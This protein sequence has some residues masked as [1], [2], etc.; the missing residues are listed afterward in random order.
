YESTIVKQRDRIKEMLAEKE[1]TDRELA[2]YREKSS[3]ISKAIVSAVAKAEEIE[4][5]SRLKYSQEITRLKA[6]HEKW[7]RYYDKIL[8][9]YPLDA[10]LVAAG[11]FN[12]RMDTILS[13]VGKPDE[14]AA[15]Q[16]QSEMRQERN[17]VRIGYI[18]VNAADKGNDTDITDLLPD[19]DPSSPVLT[20]NFDPMGRI[21]KYFAAEKEREEQEKQ[22]RA[23]R[24][25]AV[26]ATAAT[27]A[28]YADRS[29]NGFSLEEAL[30]PTEDLE[31][32][33]KDL[34]L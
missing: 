27:R 30:N 31:S 12:R 29:P 9:E 11:E 28:D 22:R 14:L 16:A 4:R 2:A 19:A 5:L 21:G 33:L 23:E 18:S 10:R 3:Q 17:D 8:D 13:R 7:T 26:K 20:G 6:F 34:G 24:S 25:N 32:I 1:E 15:T